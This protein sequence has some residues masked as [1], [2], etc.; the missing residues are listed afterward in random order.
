MP[1]VLSEGL[2][3]SNPQELRLLRQPRVRQTMAVAYYEAI[4]RY[5][6]RRDSHVGYRL[7]DAPGGALAGE[8]VTLGVEVRNQGSATMRGWD[9]VVGALPT[10]SPSIGRAR[11]GVAV[12]RQR[13]PAIAPGGSVEVDVVVTAPAHGARWT[14]LVDAEDASGSRASRSG[15]PRLTLPLSI[16]EPLPPSVCCLVLPE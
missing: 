8:Q 12:G 11:A 13:L 5:L 9:V 16:L 6:A 4:G 15:S 10:E 3:L 1:G 2:F 14:L 7:T